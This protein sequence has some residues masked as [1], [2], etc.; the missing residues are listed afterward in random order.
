MRIERTTALFAVLGAV[1][2]ALIVLPVASIFV[3]QFA[4]DF[5][6]FLSA[7]ADPA[8]LGAVGLSCFAALL[9]V[10]VT[11]AFGVPLA[12]LLARREFR[13]KGLVE[14]LI[15]LPMAVPHVVAGIALLTI[16]GTS[17]LVGGSIIQFEGAL[18]GIVVAMTFVSAPFLINSAR[19]GF[20][21]V[22]P[23]L[24]KVA[25]S[26][27]ASE[28][29]AFRRVALPLAFP[30]IF[31]GALMGWA[32]AISEVAAVIMF[33]GFFPIIAPG[34]V[35]DRFYTGGLYAGMAVAAVLLL[36]TLAAF[37]GMKYMRRRLF[38]AG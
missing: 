26:L 35:W 37:I 11:F 1:I 21:S 38:V 29:G 31:S 14:S 19:E 24:E 18:P 10:L 5:G 25:R 20:R 27:G 23:R 13:G 30:Q 7:L 32:R 22:D 3:N 8:V 2:L 17:G 34:L 6:G 16:F 36:V 28:W 9:A 15:D 4:F 12:Y 33:V